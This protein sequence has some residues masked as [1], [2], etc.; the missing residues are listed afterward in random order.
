M[1][2]FQ[3]KFDKLET[4]HIEDGELRGVLQ[5]MCHEAKYWHHL[6][7]DWAE[8]AWLNAIILGHVSLQLEIKAVRN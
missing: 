3:A 4:D 2:A 7:V 1:A 5:L 6:N 8:T